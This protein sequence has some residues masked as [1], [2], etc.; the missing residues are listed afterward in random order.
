M[1]TAFLQNM[2][3]QMNEPVL[4][5]SNVVNEVREHLDDM[6][7]DRI[8]TLANKMDGYTQI[9]TQLLTRML[10]VATNQEKE[11]GSE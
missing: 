3:D 10:E 2:T 7:H 11:G 6:D 5:I 9:I 8:V 4:G 1:K